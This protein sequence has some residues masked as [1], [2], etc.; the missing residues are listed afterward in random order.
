MYIRFDENG[1]RSRIESAYVRKKAARQT[2]PVAERAPG[3]FMGLVPGPLSVRYSSSNNI[4]TSERR[5][6]TKPTTQIKFERTGF[7]WYWLFGIRR[8][9]LY[10]NT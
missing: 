4:Q 8:T 1:C 3:K 10:P 2:D 9:S 6:L 5:L 7:H